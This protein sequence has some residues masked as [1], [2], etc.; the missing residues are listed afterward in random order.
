MLYMSGTMSKVFAISYV[1][2][3]TSQVRHETVY[4][5][6]FLRW[7][8]NTLVGRLAS[9]LIFR[10]AA[11]SRLYGWWTRLRWSRRQI[12]VVVQA[13]N[14]NQTE[15]RE[16]SGTFDTFNAFFTRKIDLSQRPVVAADRAGVAPVDGKVLVF[17][18]V[19][20]DE[21]FQIKRHTFNLREFLCDDRLAD[22]FSGGSMIVCRLSLADYHHFHFCDSG[23]PGR[24]KVI[25]GSLHAGGPYCLRSYLPYYAENRRVLTHFLSDHFGLM[26]IVEVGA[27]TVG[28]IVQEYCPGQRVIKGTRKGHFELGG[29]TVVL[30]FRPDRIA[31]DRDLLANSSAGLETYVRMGESLG[32]TTSRQS[33]SKLLK[34]T[35]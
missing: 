28:S 3:T 16:P 25:E 1:D 31:I 34:E 6:G 17:R 4:A 18:R 22:S 8:Y 11:A 30:L 29:S 21:T 35:A 5:G 19:S 12:D 26:L 20:S 33:Y 7:L 9:Y 27:L 10:H 23:W 15:Y 2:R 14:V 13:G 32:R 24:P